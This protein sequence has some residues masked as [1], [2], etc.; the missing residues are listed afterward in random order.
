MNTII[1]VSRFLGIRWIDA[2]QIQAMPLDEL[3]NCLDYLGTEIDQSQI[4]HLSET[5]L[6]RLRKTGNMRELKPEQLK[7]FMPYVTSWDLRSDRLSLAD[8]SY[9][10]M[11]LLSNQVLSRDSS[12][13]IQNF[14]FPEKFHSQLFSFPS[15]QETRAFILSM[16][17]L[18]C[19]EPE[20]VIPLIKPKYIKDLSNSLSNCPF[21]YIDRLSVVKSLLDDTVFNI[22]DIGNVEDLGIFGYQLLTDNS[23]IE[24]VD[25][26]M[27]QAISLQALAIMPPTYVAMM[28]PENVFRKFSL[29]QANFLFK[30][31]NEFLSLRQ[32][33]F[34]T[35]TLNRNDYVQNFDD[36][37]DPI[38][39]ISATEDQIS[40]IIDHFGN[41]VRQNSTKLYDR[42]SN[43][44][45]VYSASY[46]CNSYFLLFVSVCIKCLF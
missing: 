23:I 3:K 33:N 28:I 42:H 21:E 29:Q 13:L 41:Q 5:I 15:E 20:K 36:S 4:T 37:L 17:G 40:Q 2:N 7:N 11:N 39:S 19:Y 27:V 26:P 16:G 38:V 10:V 34:L 43:L 25:E 12:I 1:R 8:S 9:D 18:L 22:H 6:K 24:V 31:K 35:L 14:S 46:K 44:I 45:Y 32:I 30:F